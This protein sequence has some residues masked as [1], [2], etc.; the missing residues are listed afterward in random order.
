[1]RVAIRKV[2]GVTGVRVSLNEGL[3]VI[4]LKP[5]NT[6]TL[7]ALRQVIRNNGFVTNSAHIEA[8]GIL[9]AV[10]N[11]LTFEVGGSRERL[12]VVP[13][14]NPRPHADA[15]VVKGIVDLTDPKALRLTMQDARNP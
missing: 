10:G 1:M 2:P 5:E 12:A 14:E 6:V 3:T 7:A 15:V 8:R 9:S 13:G 11:Q 4:D